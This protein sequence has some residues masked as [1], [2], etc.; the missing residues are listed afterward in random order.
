MANLEWENKSI[1]VLI[2]AFNAGR[3]ITTVI[4]KVRNLAFETKI[5][6]IDDGS[7]DNT[8]Q[9]AQRAGVTVISHSKNSGK[10]A[11][12]RT[13]L[14]HCQKNFDI[15]VTVDA[16]DQHEVSRIPDLVRSLEQEQVAIVIGTRSVRFKFMP[17]PRVLSNFLSSLIV[18]C[19]C[20]QKIIDSQSG[21]RAI[22]TRVL[23]RLRLNTHHFETETEMLLQ[24]AQHGF[25]IGSSP[26][27]TVYF[28]QGSTSIRPLTD[29][30]R[31]IIL[32]LKDIFRR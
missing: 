5:L 16:D 4:H 1:C 9:S 27:P 19:C 10:G 31:F 2:P 14:D 8:R 3:T 7:S 12:L 24:A 29:M 30:I 32:I 11:A 17:W 18:S 26:V 15:V 20:G 25:K 28:D 22:D 13:G 6:V 21:F 23:H